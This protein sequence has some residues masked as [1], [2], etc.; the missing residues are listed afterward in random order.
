[1]TRVQIYSWLPGDKMFPDPKIV[2]LGPGPR[3]QIALTEFTIIDIAGPR[4]LLLQETG[5]NGFKRWYSGSAARKIIEAI[6]DLQRAKVR[7]IEGKK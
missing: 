1:M 3:D 2:K 5:F 7:E 6:C 4:R